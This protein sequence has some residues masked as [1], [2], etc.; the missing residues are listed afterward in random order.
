MNGSGG[1]EGG[2]AGPKSVRG[3][4][5]GQPGS[6]FK[7]VPRA[8]GSLALSSSARTFF[9]ISSGFASTLFKSTT[10]KSGARNAAMVVVLMRAPKAPVYNCSY[11]QWL[12]LLVWLLVVWLL[13]S[14]VF[15]AVELRLLQFFL[16]VLRRRKLL[17]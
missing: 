2:E 13:L 17:R 8:C 9:L 7:I 6:G 12:L 16:C 3:G 14:Y 10:C 11:W 15:A 1:A 5:A 4:K